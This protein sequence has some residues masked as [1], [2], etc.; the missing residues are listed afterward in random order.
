M[1]VSN[2]QESINVY[3][4]DNVESL[5][6]TVAIG[7]S[8]SEWCL[9]NL[10]NL[11]EDEVV[12]ACEIS[13]KYDNGIDAIF[14]ISDILYV[15]QFKYN[16]A[17]SLDSLIRFKHD[18]ERLLNKEP[19][20]DRDIVKEKCA[21][22]RDRYAQNKIIEC[23]YITNKVYTEQENG[24]IKDIRDIDSNVKIHYWDVNNMIDKIEEVSGR[25]P[26][27]FRGKR[28]NLILSKSFETDGTT[29]VGMTSLSNFATFIKKGGNLLF[30]SNI[31][32]YLSKTKVNKGIEKTLETCPDKFWYYNNGVTIVCEEY[33]PSGSV[34]SLIEP[35]I[36]NGCQTAKSILSYFTGK[37]DKESQDKGL[38]GNL[39]IKIIRTKKSNTEHEKKELRDNITRYTNSQNAVRGLDFYALDEFQRSLQKRFEQIGYYYE[40]QRGA[41]ISLKKNVR[42]KYKG[43][44]EYDYLVTKKFRGV[45]PAKEIIQAY[46]AGV[47]QL[48]NVAYGKADELTPLGSKWDDIC[49][50]KTITTPLELFL[51]PFLI[52]KYIK[53]NLGYK[54]GAN[55]FRKSAS[56]LFVTCYFMTFVEIMQKI[57]NQQYEFIEDIDI[58]ILKKIF[59]EKSINKELVNLTHSI[60]DNFL[61]DSKI[62][63]DYIQ[64]NI[65]TFLKS[66][67]KSKSECWYIL[68]K[69]IKKYINGES[70]LIQEISTLLVENE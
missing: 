68:N 49:N 21:I 58:E 41:F 42:S 23:Y 57:T 30:H 56:L 13:G 33:T 3:I 28:I 38:K 47:K 22:I 66:L 6:N 2:I 63:D 34:Y 10:F 64:D 70:K 18:C 36:V 53:N 1:L 8:F 24:Q 5:S 11:R 45:L 67:D 55:D 25:L 4:N 62:E 12:S 44:K 35:Q 43:I 61:T 20:T 37:S 69:K 39:L 48:P 7:N 40:I 31:R 60:I 14:E 65:N 15:F 27:E 54:A 17:H 29:I 16:S 51:F 46:T 50:E 26:K 19:I 32:N 9:Y 52:L 59:R